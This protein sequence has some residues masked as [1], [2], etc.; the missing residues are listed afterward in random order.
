MIPYKPLIAAGCGDSVEPA[1]D[2]MATRSVIEAA[3]DEPSS[4]APMEVNPM[5]RRSLVWVLTSLVIL[6]APS[7]V[8]AQEPEEPYLTVKI[9]KVHKNLTFD[10][11]CIDPNIPPDEWTAR[12]SRYQ[13]NIRYFV[14]N[15]EVSTT[16]FREM[17]SQDKLKLDDVKAYYDRS[18][19]HW[20][21]ATRVYLKS[22]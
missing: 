14:N 19:G 7:V 10:C 3:G 12:R 11:V 16:V 13:E 2:S 15:K 9:T 5:I 18:G 1:G 17:Y 20:F 21:D 6:A 8:P 4:F 22:R